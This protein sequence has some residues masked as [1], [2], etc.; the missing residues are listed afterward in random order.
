VTQPDSRHRRERLVGH[1][2]RSEPCTRGPL[3]RDRLYS[4]VSWRGFESA[5]AG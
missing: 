1:R 2:C 3:Q 5:R 4:G